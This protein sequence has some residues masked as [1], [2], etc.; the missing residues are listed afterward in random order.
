MVQLSTVMVPTHK[1]EAEE[2]G[3][4]AQCGLQRGLGWKEGGQSEQMEV[5]GQGLVEVLDLVAV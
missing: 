5:P 4:A 1:A 2:G 3:Q